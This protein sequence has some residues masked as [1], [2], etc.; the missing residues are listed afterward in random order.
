IAAAIM[1][2]FG[3][4]WLNRAETAARRAGE[5]FAEKAS[6]DVGA[7]ADDLLVRERATTAR[8]FDPAEIQRGQQAE[9]PPSIIP[10]ALPLVVVGVN[11][12]MSLVILPRLDVSFLADERWGGATLSAVGGVWSVVTALAAAIVVLVA[13]NHKHLPAMRASVDAGANASVLPAMSV[14]GL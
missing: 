5:G 2:G 10:A 14:A 4:W 12:V 9:T 1:L 3:L 7:A 6:F 11:L 13:V 8:E